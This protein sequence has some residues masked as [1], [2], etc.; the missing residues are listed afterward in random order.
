MSKKSTLPAAPKPSADKDERNSSESLPGWPGYRTR[1]GRS[2]LDPIDTRTEAAHVSGTLIQQLLTGR[3]RVRNPIVL[4]LMGVCGLALVAPLVFAITQM[5]SGSSFPW[6]AWALFLLT[7]LV[8]W[9]LLV[10]V[11]KNLMRRVAK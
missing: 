5:P 3:L 10:N 7:G 6:E 2:G 11:G 4:F 8:G 1:D 9:A